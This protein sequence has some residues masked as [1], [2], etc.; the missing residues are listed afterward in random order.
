MPDYAAV[1]ADAEVIYFPS[2]RTA[3]GA[4]AEPSA[5]ILEALRRENVSF[6]IGWDLMDATQQAL[7]DELVGKTGA[8][9]ELIVTRLEMAGTGRARAHCRA[10]L[11]DEGLLELRHLALRNPAAL[12]ARLNARERLTAEEAREVPSGYR[13]PPGGAEMDATLSAGEGDLGDSAAP[14]SYRAQALS[15]QYSAE[16]IVRFLR[17]RSGAGKL[18]VF[19]RAADMREGLGVPR[20]V[21]QKVQVRQLV[22]DS[23]G[24]QPVRAKL[25]TGRDGESGR[26]QIV[27]R[28]PIAAAY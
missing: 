13:L 17:E 6:A 25:L 8:A 19:L 10:V 22:L 18:L 12:L 28:A 11:R 20:Y 2:E 7:L 27:D 16:K 21:A 3:S 4:K 9:R 14:P 26:E 1:V 5:R 15:Q 24:A 23:S